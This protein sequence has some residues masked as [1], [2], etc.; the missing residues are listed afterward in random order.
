MLHVDTLLVNRLNILFNHYILHVMQIYSLDYIGNYFWFFNYLVHKS[1]YLQLGYYNT[2]EIDRQKM[3]L[4]DRLTMIRS[5]LLLADVSHVYYVIQSYEK[6]SKINRK[7]ALYYN[8]FI[9]L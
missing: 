8:F 1:L 7:L 2:S 3:Q 5:I 9:V 6:N 4:C